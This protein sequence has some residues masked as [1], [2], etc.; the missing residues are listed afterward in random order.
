MNQHLSIPLL[1]NF[2]KKLRFSSGLGRFFF[3]QQKTRRCGRV[4]GHSVMVVSGAGMGFSWLSVQSF[5][6]TW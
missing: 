3:R 5:R 4:E 6:V 2:P 1:G